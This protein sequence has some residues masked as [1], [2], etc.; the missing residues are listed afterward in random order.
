MLKMSTV[1]AIQQRGM[2]LPD[3]SDPN[4][5]FGNTKNSTRINNSR[6]AKAD[7]APPG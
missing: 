6:N 2:R 4:Q 5:L 7:S 3:E 1:L